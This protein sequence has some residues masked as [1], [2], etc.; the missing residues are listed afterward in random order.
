MAETNQLGKIFIGGLNIKTRQKTLQEI[1]GRFGPVARGNS[2]KETVCLF[3]VNIK[4]FYDMFNF[5]TWMIIF[6]FI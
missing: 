6:M 3:R 5:G 4:Y 1:F 2:L